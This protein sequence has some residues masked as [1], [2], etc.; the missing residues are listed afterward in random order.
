MGYPLEPVKSPDEP[1]GLETEDK[2]DPSLVVVAGEEWRLLYDALGR[3]TTAVIF[4]DGRESGRLAFHY[5]VAGHIAQI[6]KTGTFS[7]KTL[8]LVLDAVYA[9]AVILGALPN[10]YPVLVG[11]WPLTY[12]ATQS[13]LWNVGINNW[14]LTYAATQSGIWS[15][16]VNNFP[17]TYD[18]LDRAARLLGIIYGNLG[19]LDQN[20]VGGRNLA[21]VDLRSVSGGVLSNTD[22]VADIR[23]LHNYIED[24]F[25]DSVYATLPVS[26]STAVVQWQHT[27][28]IR[29]VPYGLKRSDTTVAMVF[30]TSDAN[31]LYTDPCDRAARLLG[32]VYGSQGQQI[33]QK[34]ATFETL[35][36][37][38]DRAARLLGII[39]GNL[40]QM[41][42]VL[43][44]GRN[45]QT[46]DLRSVSGTAQ[47]ARDWSSDF[48][49]LTDNTDTDKYRTIPMAKGKTSILKSGNATGVATT[50]IYTVTA[51]KVFYLV[52]CAHTSVGP[53]A[54]CASV[55][56]VDTGG[57]AVFRNLLK[58]D[59]VATS[60]VATSLT[61]SIP[62]P[63]VAGS[64][65][66][67]TSNIAGLVADASIIGWEE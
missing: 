40:G 67:V 52:G 14:P 44:G 8:F 64:V 42:Q 16:G 13:G 11:N 2:I 33:Q 10:P 26:G 54:G 19:Q 34:A 61:P 48:K 12:A 62:M 20:L 51:G 66:R 23:S 65:F 55:L 50:I 15:V 25:A 5:D 37:P 4:A 9:N 35:T 58:L 31:D 29:V 60:A 59:S 63:F 30:E 53:A 45:L 28:A 39:Y 7:E 24:R 1:Y 43:V 38:V 17:A 41:D 36:D 27:G 56:Q 22:F 47:T 21:T 32:R 46:Q 57:D 6:E 3:V 18:V 49:T